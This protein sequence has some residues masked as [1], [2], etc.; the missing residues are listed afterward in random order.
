VKNLLSSS[1][2]SKIIK[3][4]RIKT[5]ILSI[6][7][8]GQENWSLT[9]KEEHMMSMFQGKVLRR[10]FVPNRDKVKGGGGGEKYIMKS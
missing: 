5:L 9:L 6:V 2:L 3:T 4:G 10:I 8:Y 7:L 1:L